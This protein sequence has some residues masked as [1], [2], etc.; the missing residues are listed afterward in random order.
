MCGGVCA[1]VWR[2]YFEM[3]VKDVGILVKVSMWCQWGVEGL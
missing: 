2:V 1:G 3:F